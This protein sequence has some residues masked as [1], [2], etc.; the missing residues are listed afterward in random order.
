M[1]GY[2]DGSVEFLGRHFAEQCGL[3]KEGTL[4]G[5]ERWRE[6]EERR[7]RRRV[8]VEEEENFYKK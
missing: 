1:P 2:Q 8:R 7:E 4:G 3:R 6:F 5:G